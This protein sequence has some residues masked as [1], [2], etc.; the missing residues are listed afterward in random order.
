[1]AYYEVRWSGLAY[2]EADDEN[3]AKD[4]ALDKDVIFAEENICY[5]NEVSRDA[6]AILI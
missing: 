5:T 6:I 4:K 1:M 3:E 2:V